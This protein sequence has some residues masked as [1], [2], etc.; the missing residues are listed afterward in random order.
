MNPFLTQVYTEI[1]L[2]FREREAVFWGFIF[3]VL[4]IVILGLLF[5]NDDDA[6]AKTTLNVDRQISELAE[7]KQALDQD[8]TLNI[9]YAPADSLR[10]QIGAGELNH[11]ILLSGDSL[12]PIVLVYPS[13]SELPFEQQIKPIVERLI[14]RYQLIQSGQTQAMHRIEKI[15][16]ESAAGNEVNYVSWLTPGVLALNLFLSCIFGIGISI[17]MDKRQGKLKKIATTPLE[18]WKFIMAISIQRMIVLMIQ[19][20]AIIVAAYLIFDVQIIGNEIELLIAL[21]ISVLSFM[22]FGFMIAA[23]SNTIEKAVTLSN[24]FF[25]ASMLISGA[26]FSNTGLPDFLMVIADLLPVTMSVEMVR[27]VYAFGDSLIDYTWSILGLVAWF[28]IA[29]GISV[30]FFQWVND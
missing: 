17:V 16:I 25:I 8:P 12:Q 7:L 13:V 18:K 6:F 24:V 11:A 19:A 2:H 3:P 28:F 30:R 10:L 23:F 21:L 5:S 22:V 27:G 26:Y 14:F 4:I 9:H 29:M 1:K 15:H 20:V